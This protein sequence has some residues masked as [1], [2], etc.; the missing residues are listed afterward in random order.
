MALLLE[1]S[2][3]SLFVPGISHDATIGLLNA[4]SF[5]GIARTRT[6]Q[7]LVQADLSGI[8]G[9]IYGHYTGHDRMM[10]GDSRCKVV[11]LSSV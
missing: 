11:K 4:C 7:L 9:S 3:L 1:P 2:T 5:S 6:S 10:Q 8:F